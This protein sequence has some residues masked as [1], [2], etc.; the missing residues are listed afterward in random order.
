MVNKEIIQGPTVNLV[1]TSATSIIHRVDVVQL[2]EATVEDS[3]RSRNM[4]SSSTSRRASSSGGMVYSGKSLP[5]RGLRF[6]W[7]KVMA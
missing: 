5:L 1:F 4:F 2:R 3:H 7:I 6:G